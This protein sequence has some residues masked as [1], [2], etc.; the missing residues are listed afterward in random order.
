MKSLILK[1]TMFLCTAVVLMGLAAQAQSLKFS[2]PFA[3]DA[4]GKSL[5]AGVYTV[6]P[7]SDST[8]VYVIR[9]NNTH[10]GVLLSTRM[11]IS[12]GSTETKAVFRPAPGGYCLTELWDGSMGRALQTPKGRNSILAA[13][14]VVIN[15]TK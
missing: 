1:S 8:G 11:A 5:P 6:H 9:N 14:K 10:E 15:A 13:P 2:I 4:N 7:A 3:F 12:Y